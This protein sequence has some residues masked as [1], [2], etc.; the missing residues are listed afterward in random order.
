MP[1]IAMVIVTLLFMLLRPLYIDSGSGRLE[2]ESL[3]VL[4]SMVCTGSLIVV[5]YFLLR[6]DP[7]ETE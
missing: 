3:A 2:S 1:A 4:G 6:P 7:W 5:L